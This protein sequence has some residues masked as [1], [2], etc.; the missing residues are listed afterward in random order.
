MSADHATTEY[1]TLPGSPGRRFG[2]DG[3]IW[4]CRGPV[5]LPGNRGGTRVGLDGAWRLLEPTDDGS[6]T[7]RADPQKSPGTRGGTNAAR[8]IL[9]AF[10]DGDRPPM[11]V[12]FHNGDYTDMRPT[13]MTWAPPSAAAKPVRG[14]Q[15]PCWSGANISPNGGR[16]RARK[17]YPLGD[18]E[19]CGKP[20][21]DRHHAD[22]NTANNAATNVV[23]VCRRCH[24]EIDGRLTKLADCGRQ[25]KPDPPKP[26]SR[27]E[28]L[29]RPLRRGLCSR[30]Y[31]KDRRAR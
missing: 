28:R 8:L 5:R 23:I 19:I 17:I 12:R 20:A 25:R 13:N 2:S 22:G 11:I 26:C 16:K 18:C 14:E 3:T 6:G 4:S 27:C 9:A 31:D 15:H 7:M 10:T 29:Y 21:T 1:R 24:M 30:C